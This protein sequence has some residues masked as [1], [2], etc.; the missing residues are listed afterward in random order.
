M[1]TVR[2]WS[3]HARK[4]WY[5]I[6]P[7]RHT[8]PSRTSMSARTIP[9]LTAKSSPMVISATASALRPGARSTGIPR[10]VAPGMSTLV[11]SPRHDPIARS[12]RSRTG[13]FTLS[14]STTRRSAPSATMRSASCSEL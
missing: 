12:G 10:A 7:S 11:G 13:P 5:G 14:L 4:R 6:V 9:R 1:P 2:S 3:S 8:W